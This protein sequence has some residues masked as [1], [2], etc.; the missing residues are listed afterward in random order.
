[1]ATPFVRGFHCD[2]DTI[3]YPY[4][5]STVSSGVCYFVGSGVNVIL[6]LTLEYFNLISESSNQQHRDQDG[7]THPIS[8]IYLRNVYCR[9]LIWLFGSFASEFLTDIAKVTAGRLRPHFLDVCKPM[10]S[11][12][13]QYLPAEAYCNL[14]GNRYTYVTNYYCTGIDSKQKDTRLS[15]LSG[16]SSYSA[17]SAAFAAFYIQSVVDSRKFGLLKPTIQVLIISAA[18]YTGLT[19]VSDYKHH[20]QDVLA[21]LLLGTTVASLL[22]S[23]V[24]PSFY[25]TYTSLNSSKRTQSRAQGAEELNSFSY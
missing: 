10:V 22:C 2:D 1:M 6:I 25:K 13:S 20:W 5:D 12:G 21:G 23:Q 15:F 9:L 4:K 18:F 24:W 19:R 17:Y 3:K 11:N 7:S 8:K 14:D 16:H